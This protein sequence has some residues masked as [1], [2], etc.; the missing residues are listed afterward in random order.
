MV[1]TFRLWTGHA[2]RS[3]ALRKQAQS[4]RAACVAGAGCRIAR[5]RSAAPAPG[6]GSQPRL[7]ALQPLGTSVGTTAGPPVCG[8][9]GATP[10]PDAVFAVAAHGDAQSAGAGAT[11][12]EER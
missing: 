11:P 5:L 2:P 12:G 3:D 8:G 9:R 6:P 10:D 4:S 7:C 1:A